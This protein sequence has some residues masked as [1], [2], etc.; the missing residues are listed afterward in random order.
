[1]I[2]YERI[3]F[4]ADNFDINGLQRPDPTQQA[5]IS[6]G[7]YEHRSCSSKYWSLINYSHHEKYIVQLF[8]DVYPA[9][10]CAGL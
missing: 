1:M 5:A 3:F 10:F 8:F 6:A 4:I 2:F 9:S 7:C